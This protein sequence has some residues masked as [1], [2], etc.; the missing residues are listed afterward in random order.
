MPRK[1]PAGAVGAAVLGLTPA[2]RRMSAGLAAALSL[3]AVAGMALTTAAPAHADTTSGLLLR[4]KLDETSGTVA[5]DSSGNGRNGTV[6]GTADWKGAE[7]LGF[8][9]SNTYVKVPDNIMAGLNSITVDFDVWIDRTMGKPYFLYGF[10]NSSGTSG[11]G[12]LFSTGNQF[13]T[14]ITSSNSAAE[15]QTRPGSSYQLA[16]GMWKHVTYTQTGNTG[17]LYENGVEKARNTAVTLTPGSIG[18]GTT[19]AN[20]IG[21]SLYSSDLYFH[22]RMRDFRVYN[23]A[24]SA[25]ET[26]AQATQTEVQWKQ[27]QALAF[28]NQAIAVFQDPVI[29]P[30]IIFPSDYTGDINNLQKPPNWTDEYGQTPTSWPTPTTAKSPLFTVGQI[31]AIEDAVITAVQPADGSTNYRLNIFYDGM[32]DRV[33]AQTD[34][35]A[36][37]TDPLATQY[38]GKLVIKSD[39]AVPGKCAPHQTTQANSLATAATPATGVGDVKTQLQWKQVQALA[40]YNCALTAFDDPTIGPVIIFPKDYTGDINNLQKPPG[41]TD[42]SGHVPASWPAP[43]TAKSPQ[44]TLA[45]I[46]NIQTAAVSKIAGA[47]SDTTNYGVDVYYDGMSDRVVVATDAPPSVTDSLVTAY[48]NQVVIKPTTTPTFTDN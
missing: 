28:Y 42:Q 45:Q 7:G 30:V 26:L 18:G 3:V 22:G 13:R 6:N 35:P 1:N 37:V 4:Y 2:R 11:N 34:A 36:S 39:A 16:R 15:Q 10:G 44:F 41:W 12:Y 25:S 48:P 23:R 32:S 33:V 24:L 19:T 47:S 17:I 9:G 40:D 29:G 21:R 38:A 27:V 8:N 31:S 46:Q 43:T 14:G 5:H 20:Y